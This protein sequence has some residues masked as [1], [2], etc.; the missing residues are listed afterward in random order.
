MYDKY[1]N[2]QFFCLLCEDNFDIIRIL[3]NLTMVKF[4]GVAFSNRTAAFTGKRYIDLAENLHGQQLIYDIN[5][6]RSLCVD[7]LYRNNLFR[8]I[9]TPLHD[10]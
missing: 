10:C 2:S 8:D 5:E 7:E 1:V 9:P 4:G 6:G 3:Q